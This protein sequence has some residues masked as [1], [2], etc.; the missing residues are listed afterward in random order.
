MPARFIAFDLLHLGDHSLLEVPLHDRRR[1]LVELVDEGP[2]WSSSPSY[3]DGAALLAAA[4]SRGLEGVMA[5]R[6]DSLYEPGRRSSAWRKI[7]V[8]RRQEMVVG[9][10]V[11]GEKGRAGQIG[12]LLLGYHEPAGGPLRFAG[13]VGTGF[14][15]TELARLAGLFARLETDVCPFDP[16]P[17]AAEL[18]RGP[19]WL[20]PE[21][22]AEIQFGEWTD[23]GR[24]RHPSY[25]GLRADK[26]SA[27]VV[28]E[29]P[30]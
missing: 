29:E 28:R 3:D 12:A 30:P 5:K 16:V 4:T 22:V 11:P 13:R 1:L 25:L 27:E 14:T 2:A 21:L 23:D 26:R 17:P 24:L 10:W 7:K 18:R 9:G 20:R 15:Q 6:T 8:R 19:T